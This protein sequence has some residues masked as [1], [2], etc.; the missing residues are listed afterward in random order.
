KYNYLRSLC[1]GACLPSLDVSIIFTIMNEIGTEFHRAHLATWL[2]TS[3]AM[4]C[5]ATLP[6][7]GKLS[8][9]FGRKYIMLLLVALFFVG[10]VGCGVST[11]MN[12]IIFSRVL[13]GFGGGGLQLMSN[14]VIQ[15]LI[16]PHKRGQYQSYV[17]SVQTLGIALGSPAGGFITD[18]LDWRYCFKLNIIPL[19]AI[20]YFYIFHFT[21][22]N[23]ME[24]KNDKNQYGYGLWKKLKTIDFLG[25]FILALA[26]LSFATT[27]LLGGNTREWNDP[28]IISAIITTI[29][30]FI[31]F[32]FYQVFWASYP[33]ISRTCIVN[34]N[35]IC[36]S[37]AYFFICMSNGSVD[38]TI[39]QFFMG[40]L[41]F[42]TSQSGM[43]TMMNALAVP[44]GCYCAGQYIRYNQGCFRKWLLASATSYTGS[45]LIMSYWMV[46]KIPFILGITCMALLGFGFGSSL[47]S[48][49]VSVTTDV[50]STD[51][52]SAM[53]IMMLFR[54]MGLL[55]GTAI[56][57]SIIQNSLKTLLEAKINGPS[58]EQLINFI[59]TSIRQVHTLPPHLQ[60][61]VADVLGQS[62]QKAYIFMAVSCLIALIPI[63][64]LKDLEFKKY[65]K[66][67]TLMNNDD[68]I[69]V[70]TPSHA[71]ITNTIQQNTLSS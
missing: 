61:L 28:L 65:F 69:V 56:S 23:V 10:S 51:V 52:A 43:W 68:E 7:A 2:H 4:S 17:S 5:L 59:R 49:L 34:R 47:V 11:S 63:V 31:I 26:N 20:G 33:L 53:S 40:V 50:P 67:D 13:A 44:I 46:S 6:L 54:S 21:N 3:Y 41:G 70:T 57:S 29:S 27:V 64:Y 60:Q 55:Y 19:I 45:I 30:S 9:V 62:L 58:A 66:D 1:I 24:D 18:T 8:D 39:P 71:N 35:V 22:Y 14:V 25:A 15:D 36:S 38:F 37:L 42:S 16:P 32:G 48:L 12:Q